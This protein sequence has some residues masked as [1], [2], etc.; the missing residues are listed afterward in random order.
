MG[1]PNPNDTKFE[2]QKS[3]SEIAGLKNQADDNLG[4]GADK[5]DAEAAKGISDNLE[6]DKK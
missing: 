4:A 1:Q 3:D 5:S 6:S 2:Q